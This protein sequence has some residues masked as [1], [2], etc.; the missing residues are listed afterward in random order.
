[1]DGGWAVRVCGERVEGE[2]VAPVEAGYAGAGDELGLGL[3]F[4]GR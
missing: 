2:E 4:V 3:I 1:M